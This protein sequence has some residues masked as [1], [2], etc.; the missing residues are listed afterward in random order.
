[1]KSK[2][3]LN[4]VREP[5][6]KESL[7][8]ERSPS[9]LDTQLLAA[10]EQ[11]LRSETALLPATPSVVMLVVGEPLAVDGHYPSFKEVADA[12]ERL[13]HER[14]IRRVLIGYEPHIMLRASDERRVLEPPPRPKAS[15]EMRN[16]A[17]EVQRELA[18]EYPTVPPART[19]ER[20]PALLEISLAP[21]AA[22][23]TVAAE[24][25]PPTPAVLTPS[26]E[27]ETKTHTD[28]QQGVLADIEEERLILYRVSIVVLGL[29]GLGLLRSIALQWLGR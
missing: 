26:T 29:V 18:M 22:I 15:V 6:A 20:R 16:L 13:T 14:C 5:E 11:Y 24:T 12:L 23:A 27:T 10:L 21:P 7:V 8:V 19:V 9:S 3:V 28:F 25:A 1:M 2:E 4:L 17:A